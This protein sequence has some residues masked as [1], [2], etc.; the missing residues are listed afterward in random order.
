MM[1]GNNTSNTKLSDLKKWQKKLGR[2][3][4]LG[5]IKYA[6]KDARCQDSF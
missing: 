1:T 6:S 2:N 5:M 4:K 3:E